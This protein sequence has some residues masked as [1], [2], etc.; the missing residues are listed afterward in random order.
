[1]GLGSALLC[2][3]GVWI[4]SVGGV[5]RLIALYYGKIEYNIVYSSFS[6][7]V[8]MYLVW[9]IPSGVCLTAPSN[10]ETAEL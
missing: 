1:M 7:V 4:Q 10:A 9:G 3:G 5:K 8:K 6:L 2:L